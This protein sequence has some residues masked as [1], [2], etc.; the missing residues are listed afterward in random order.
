M[1]NPNYKIML[2]DDDSFLIN[3]YSMKFGKSG[4]EVTAATSAADALK[5]LKEGYVPDIILLDIIMPGMD[6]L[7]LLEEIKKENLGSTATKIMLTNQSDAADIEKAKSLGID[8]Y[9]VKATTI[10][11]EVITNVL[12]IYN[13][14]HG[15]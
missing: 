1:A 6:G 4:F 10:P 9:I 3:M 11:S 7:Q 12:D 5:K 8:G 13:K 14:K 2:V 15:V